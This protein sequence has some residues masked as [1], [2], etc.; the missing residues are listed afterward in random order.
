M[1]ASGFEVRHVE[2]LRE[3]YAKT[4]RAWVANLEANWDV[5]IPPEVTTHRRLGAPIVWLKRASL[6]AMRLHDRE[7]L[8]RQRDFNR[9]VK[10]ELNALRRAVAEL[11]AELQSRP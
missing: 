4:L 10:E 9:Q 8:K 6:L 11:A 5:W 2:S 7:I 3:H 1:Q